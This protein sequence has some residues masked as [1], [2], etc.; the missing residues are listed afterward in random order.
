MIYR[1][2]RNFITDNDGIGVIEVVLIL[3]VLIGLVI[4]FKEQIGKLLNNIFKEINSQSK[5]VY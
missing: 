3:V 5:E 1:E 2:L 4:I